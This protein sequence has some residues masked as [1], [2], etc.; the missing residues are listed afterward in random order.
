MKKDEKAVTTLDKPELPAAGPPFFVEAEKML[1]RFAEISRE[2]GTRAYDFFRERGGEW[3]R[4]LED[5]FKA[6]TDLLRYVPIEITETDGIVKVNADVAGYKPEE[7]ELSVENNIL[8]LSGKTERREE[9]KDEDLVYSDFRSDRFFRQFTLPSP[10][11]AAKA[12]AELKD[13]ILHIDLP[14]TAKTEPVTKI[15]VAASGK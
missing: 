6:E 4:E 1:D 2:I 10:V 12:T 14:K 13:G 11:D 9:K 8:M 7:I 3:G 5:W 15:A